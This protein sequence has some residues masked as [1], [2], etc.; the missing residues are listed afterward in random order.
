LRYHHIAWT[1]SRGVKEMNGTRIEALYATNISA[2]LWPPLPLLH[3]RLGLA[4][5]HFSIR[6]LIGPRLPTFSPPYQGDL[7][8]THQ[9]RKLV[10]L[11]ASEGSRLFLR[12]LE[13]DDKSRSFSSRRIRR[14]FRITMSRHCWISQC[15]PY[16]GGLIKRLRAS[17]PRPQGG[18]KEAVFHRSCNPPLTHRPPHSDNSSHAWLSLPTGGGGL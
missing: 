1:K 3:G 13:V 15:F 7:C 11:S 4:P 14:S 8:I 2:S 17:R 6:E 9:F 10:I 16:Q 12:S 5:K 18:Q